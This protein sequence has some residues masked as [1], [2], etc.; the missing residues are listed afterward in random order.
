MLTQHLA[1]WGP[2]LPSVEQNLS[3][4]SLL[5]SEKHWLH[6]DVPAHLGG[7]LISL[8]PCHFYVDDKTLTHPRARIMHAS[9]SSDQQHT[10][11]PET[12]THSTDLPEQR[13]DD[14]QRSNP[15]GPFL[16]TGTEGKL[17]LPF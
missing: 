10:T 3:F 15:K 13:Q 14:A 4:W 17:Q 8:P 2:F 9:S 11:S 6:A 7:H 5:F 16:P 1:V 12:Q